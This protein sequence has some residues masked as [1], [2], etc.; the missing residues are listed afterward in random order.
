MKHISI[1]GFDGVGKTTISNIVAK[2]LGFKFIEKPLHELFD[3]GDSFDEYLRIRDKVNSNPDRNFT[4]LFYGLGSVYMYGKYKDNNIVTDR[5]LCSNYAWSGAEYNQDVYDFLLSKL[6]KPALT[7]ILYATPSTILQ[8][9]K[10]RN[11]NDSDIKKISLSSMIY[12]KMEFFCKKYKL[13]TLWIET[14]FSTPTENSELILKR[15]KEI[16]DNSNKEPEFIKI[17]G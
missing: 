3:E 5:H 16:E 13:E 2:E 8:R 14:D 11:P 15:F 10:Q 12:E 9:L 7:V 1:E 6:G 17:G 4:S